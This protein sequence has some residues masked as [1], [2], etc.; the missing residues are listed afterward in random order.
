VDAFELAGAAL[1]LTISTA[2]VLAALLLLLSPNVL[3]RG[4]RGLAFG[5]A[6]IGGLAVATFGLAGALL[7]QT[8][9]AVVGAVAFSGLLLVARNLGLGDAWSYLRT[10]D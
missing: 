3:A 2:V 4:L 9:A 1:A 6:L 10:L 8:T 7:P 5:G